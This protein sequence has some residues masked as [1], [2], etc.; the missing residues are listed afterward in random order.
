MVSA[1]LL[2]YVG[3][4]TKYLEVFGAKG[5]LMYTLDLGYYTITDPTILV[6]L[7]MTIGFFSL[8]IFTVAIEIK[9]GC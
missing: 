5:K 8:I 6:P 9:K 2:S 3:N 7:L 1:M 4:Q